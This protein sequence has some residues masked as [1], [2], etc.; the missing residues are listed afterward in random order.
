MTRITRC[1]I[2][3]GAAISKNKWIWNQKGNIKIPIREYTGQ[4]K[5]Y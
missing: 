3:T 5:K 1:L 4:E 2:A